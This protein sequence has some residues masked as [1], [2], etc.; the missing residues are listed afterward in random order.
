MLIYIN[1][2]RQEEEVSVM[3]SKQD[4]LL[5]IMMYDFAVQDTALYLDLRKNEPEAQCYYNRNKQLLQMCKQEYEKY[6]GML[7]NRSV[8][9]DDYDSYVE[10]TW[11][12]EKFEEEDN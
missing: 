8:F 1:L 11:P 10:S 6:F 3:K 2:L 4:L 7:S 9:N 5:D 12:W